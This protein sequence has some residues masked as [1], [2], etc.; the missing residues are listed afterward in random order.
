MPPAYIRRNY[1]RYKEH[2]NTIWKRKFSATKKVLFNVVTIISYAFSPATNKSLHTVLIKICI[3]VQNVACLSCCCHHCWN[4]P[5]TASLCWHPLFS[6]H[7]C[8]ASVDECQLCAIFF[9]HESIQWHTFASYTL[10]CQSPLCQT[11]PLLPFATPLQNVT[12]YWQK[13]SASIAIPP[14]STSD[15]ASQHNKEN[16]N[17]SAALV[18]SSFH[19]MRIH[20]LKKIYTYLGNYISHLILKV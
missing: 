15:V 16:I 14:T 13:G 8:S 4:A 6:P 18:H 3:A 7:K 1:S 5:P 20:T 17:F 10:P 11:A 12:E 19:F 2:N 9:L